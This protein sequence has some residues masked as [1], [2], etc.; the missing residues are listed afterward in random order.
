MSDQAY[1]RFDDGLAL[2]AL[3]RA[4]CKINKVA[5][6]GAGTLGGGIA[7]CFAD[8]GIAVALKDV[9]RRTLNRGL[10]RIHEN[11]QL[12]VQRGQLV[13]AQVQP[14]MELLFTTFDYADL[15]D[16]DLIIEAT[17]E[18]LESKHQVFLALDQIC[19]AGAIFATHTSSLDIEALANTV[20]R[21]QA[22]VGLRFF[23]PASD[24]RQVEIVPC[25]ATAAD[26]V[27]AVVEIVWRIG[28]RPVLCGNAA[29][30]N[31]IEV[32]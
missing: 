12:H 19:K 7:M 9:D 14:R 27:T 16:A 18:K 32:H 29:E 13:A 21:P 10:R 5:V 24:M 26:A 4:P 25:H 6:I 20:S 30:S 17:C 3:N 11:Y 8:V 28:K 23:S 2:S 31:F 1:Y 15:S 22:V